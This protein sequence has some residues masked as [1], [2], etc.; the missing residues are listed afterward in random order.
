VT[1][2]FFYS[3]SRLLVAVV[4]IGIVAGGLAISAVDWPIALGFGFFWSVGAEPLIFENFFPGSY[5]EKRNLQPLT[6]G[7]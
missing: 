7:G 3:V 5:K 2:T 1:S 6:A 4:F